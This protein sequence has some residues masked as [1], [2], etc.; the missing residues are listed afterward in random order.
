MNRA[1]SSPTPSKLKTSMCL[2]PIEG[3]INGRSEAATRTDKI[4]SV[5]L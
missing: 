2:T 1:K 5:Q 4:I 3:T